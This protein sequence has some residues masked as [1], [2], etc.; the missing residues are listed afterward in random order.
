MDPQQNGYILIALI[1]IIILIVIV[2]ERLSKIITQLEEN[3]RLQR[4]SIGEASRND[5]KRA[6]WKCPKCGKLNA[7]TTFQCTGCEYKLV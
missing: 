7:N 5:L 3:N 2:I 6:N 4:S 1:V